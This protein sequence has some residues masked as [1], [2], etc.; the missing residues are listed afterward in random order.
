MYNKIKEFCKSK[1]I[2]INKMEQDLGFA[3][4]YISKLNNSSPSVANAKK[5][6]DYLH[7]NINK[8]IE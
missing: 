5:I 1:K 4:G 8:L 7:V 3:K 2:S 6:A